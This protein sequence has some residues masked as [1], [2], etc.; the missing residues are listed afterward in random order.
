MPTGNCQNS[1]GRPRLPESLLASIVLCGG[2]SQRMGADK[3]LM[4]FGEETLLQRVCRILTDVTPTVIVVANPAQ[5]LPALSTNVRVV[6]DQYP[7]EGPLGGLVTGLSSLVESNTEQSAAAAF[8]CACDSP[9]PSAR[10]VEVM[11]QCLA[12]KT[13]ADCHV[14][15]HQ[16]KTQPMHAI[17]RCSVLGTATALFEAGERSLQKLLRQLNV[18]ETAAETYQTLDPELLF[19][20]NVNTPQDLAAARRRLI[21]PDARS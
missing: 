9:F 15:T 10:V 16:S 14:V 1:L 19:L 11:M 12:Q 17:Y 20:K 13:D 2:Q 18:L 7:D 21:T 4:E 6:R 5:E 8:L 3:A